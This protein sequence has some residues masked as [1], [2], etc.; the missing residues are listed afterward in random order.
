MRESI[1]I[2]RKAHY[3]LLIP[4]REINAILF[5]I[6]GFGQRSSDF[7]H[8]FEFLKDSNCLVVAPEA[9][10]KFYNKKG[11]GVATWMTSYE[12]LDEIEDYVNYLNLLLDRITQRY[13][14]DRIHALGFSQGTSTLMRWAKQINPSFDE[15]FLC[16]GSVPPELNPLDVRGI[17]SN[18]KY[19]YGDQDKLHS[20][21]KAKEQI[22]RLEVLNLKFEAI[23]FSGR[24]EIS[25]KCKS[26]LLKAIN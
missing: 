5:V 22:K 26:D 18:I 16:S 14:V 11:E 13:P 25:E 24:H 20:L 15:I 6:H 4:N 7:I 17:G 9:I 23:P 3:D 10:S 12:R 21:E 19:Y 1:I 2:E 8:E